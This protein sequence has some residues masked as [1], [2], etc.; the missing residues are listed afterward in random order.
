MKEI[1][2]W[3]LRA[4]RV[5]LGRSFSVL[6]RIFARGARM[7]A[8]FIVCVTGTAGME[9]LFSRCK[10]LSVHHLSPEFA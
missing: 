7:P 2:R 4:D 3:Q 8:K 10:F 9:V 5:G 6:R 1:N